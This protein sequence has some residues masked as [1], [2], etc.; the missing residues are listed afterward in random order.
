MMRYMPSYASSPLKAS[1]LLQTLGSVNQKLFLSYNVSQ[2]ED[3]EGSVIKV[4]EQVVG[5]LHLRDRVNK[6]KVVNKLDLRVR[7]NK[8]FLLLVIS[9][10][11]N[12]VCSILPF[13]DFLCTQQY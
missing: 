10:P 1:Q 13:L 3:E 5:K 4:L 8:G 11:Q 12:K 9:L 7:V 6:K 2:D